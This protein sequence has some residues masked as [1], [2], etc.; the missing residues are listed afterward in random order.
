MGKKPIIVTGG[1]GYI[2][3]HT[4]K[5]LFENGY[6]PIVVDL[7]DP[8]FA[9]AHQWA[10]FVRG[11]IGD[12]ALMV[13]VIKEHKPVAIIHMAASAEVGESA[14]NPEKYY[15]NNVS[16]SLSLLSAMKECGL[17][18][19][20]FS[21]TCAV[22][23]LVEK[24][25]ITED[26]PR[27]PINVY[28][29]SKFMVELILEDFAR[30]Y[31]FSFV[32]FRYFNA[33]GADPSGEIGEMHDPETHLI[34]RA[35]MASAGIVS[36]LDIFGDDYATHDGTC[37]RDY[38][39]VNDLSRAHTIGVEYL[40]KNGAPTFMNLGTGKGASVKEILN[41]AHKATNRAVPIK[42]KERRI[43]DSP[44]LI[45]E[46]DKARKIL[47]FETTYNDIDE[48]VLTAW[49]FHKRHWNIR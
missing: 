5:Y 7:I 39:H 22:Y 16:G 47:G 26:V 12:K 14:S 18:K 42:I 44:I 34:P 8:K 25:P 4:V 20:V 11:D 32:A 35:L 19:I 36:H 23:G 48:I 17:D 33:C 6:A 28:G 31:G 27:N 40:L 1:A 13:Q 9:I 41:A 10:K 29:R 49:K 15:T 46:P 3:L 38:I 24:V 43:G 45:A 21:S 30:S 2:G 37:L